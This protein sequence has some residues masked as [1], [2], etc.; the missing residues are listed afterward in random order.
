MPSWNW[1]TIVM[2][3]V[4]QPHFSMIFQSPS[5]LTV[6]KAATSSRKNVWNS[7]V[8]QTFL[9]ELMGGKDHVSGP[10]TCAEAALALGEET[11]LQVAEQRVV[12][13]TG[14]SLACYRQKGYSSVVVAELMVSFAL[15]DV[16]NCSVPKFLWQMLLVPHGLAGTD[17]L[18]SCEWIHHMS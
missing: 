12:E 2:N 11:L 1:L 10:S 17:L 7:I 13:D 14:Q 18:A 8:D 6:S 5:Q 16:D 15:V 9:L 3:L 4:G